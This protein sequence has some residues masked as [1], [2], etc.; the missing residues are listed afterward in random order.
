[1]QN[2]QKFI[3]FAFSPFE[4]PHRDIFHPPSRRGTCLEIRL[5]TQDRRDVDPYNINCINILR[6]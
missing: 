5:L 4:Y 6:N 1:M 3:I 2:T